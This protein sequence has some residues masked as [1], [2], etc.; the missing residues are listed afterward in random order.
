MAGLAVGVL[1]LESIVRAPLVVVADPVVAASGPPVAVE[2]LGGGGAALLARPA[3]SVLAF[4]N[5]DPGSGLF[6]WVARDRLAVVSDPDGDVDL[7]AVGDL[8]V[9]S[10]RLVV[11]A[12]DVVAAWGADADTGDGSPARAR[13]HRGR[14]RLGLIVVVHAPVGEAAVTVGSG[15]GAVAFPTA[16]AGLCPPMV[17]P[18]AG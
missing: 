15:A 10:G 11:G 18:L 7:T 12:P 1:Q 3:G 4:A 13:M 2:E 14:T 9:R 6:V 16:S 17:L 8:T 5:P